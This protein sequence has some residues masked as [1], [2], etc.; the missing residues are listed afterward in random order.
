SDTID[1][2][3]NG[4]NYGQDGATGGPTE[5]YLDGNPV[6]FLNGGTGGRGAHCIISNSNGDGANG[7]TG[8]IIT[9]YQDWFNSGVFDITQENIINLGNQNLIIRY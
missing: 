5:V 8:N 7:S 9:T 4:N 6:I 1:N 3:A 2:Y